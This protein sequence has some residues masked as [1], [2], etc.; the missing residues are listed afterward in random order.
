MKSLRKNPKETKEF[1]HLLRYIANCL[2]GPNQCDSQNID[3]DRKREK[4]EHF[5]DA[6]LYSPDINRGFSKKI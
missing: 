6:F 2:S 3:K 5:S 4:P 1:T